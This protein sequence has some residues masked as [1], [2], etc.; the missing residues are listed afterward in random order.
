MDFID[1]RP[2]Y[3][4]NLQLF[5]M[6]AINS[7][8]YDK[9][10]NCLKYAQL[11]LNSLWVVLLNLHF[12]VLVPYPPFSTSFWPMEVLILLTTLLHLVN[13]LIIY[14]FGISR[15]YGSLNCLIL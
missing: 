3:I 6:E 1:L 13:L 7:P 10:V 14:R 8:L 4:K 2:S 9:R 12:Y 5:I 15:L 11:I